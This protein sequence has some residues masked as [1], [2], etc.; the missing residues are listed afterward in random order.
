MIIRV[1][2]GFHGVS[3]ARLR[4]FVVSCGDGFGP[5]YNAAQPAKQASQQRGFQG[6]ASD[7]GAAYLGGGEGLVVIS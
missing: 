5:L 3:W 1:N 2:F 7:G 4:L 6:F